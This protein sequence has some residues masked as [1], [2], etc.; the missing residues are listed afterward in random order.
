MTWGEMLSDA[1]EHITKA[2]EKYGRNEYM[3]GALELGFATARIIQAV[4]LIDSQ[5]RTSARG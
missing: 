1:Q 3:E 2:T 4:E 5:I